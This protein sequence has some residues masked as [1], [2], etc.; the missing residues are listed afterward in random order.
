MDRPSAATRTRTTTCVLAL[1]S[2]YIATWAVVSGSDP[3]MVATWW[4]TGAGLVR[5]LAGGAA[6]R[7]AADDERPSL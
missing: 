6:Q 4:L 5:V 3:A 2:A 1:W 7:D